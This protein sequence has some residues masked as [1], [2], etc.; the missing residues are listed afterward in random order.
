M[1]SQIKLRYT[2]EEYLAIERSN[3]EQK[4]EYY[5]GGIFALAESSERHNLIV[6]N[7]VRE[8]SIQMKGRPCKVYSNDMRVKVAPTGLYT[9]PDV[10]TL[11]GEAK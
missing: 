6:T 3:T 2:P 5:A 10:V 9:Y 7:I 8:L 1:P 4:N 11:C